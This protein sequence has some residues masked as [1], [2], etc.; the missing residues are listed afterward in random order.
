MII[1]KLKKWLIVCAVMPINLL[2]FGYDREYEFVYN[3]YQDGFGYKIFLTPQ[4][5][6][7]SATVD[8]YFGSSIDIKIPEYVLA[9]KD[10]DDMTSPM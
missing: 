9:L 4:Y 6:E 8:Y 3:D 1:K 7:N 10:T 5:G 2:A